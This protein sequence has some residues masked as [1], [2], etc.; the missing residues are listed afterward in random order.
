VQ[1]IP[2]HT[3]APV[4]VLRITTPPRRDAGETQIKTFLRHDGCPTLSAALTTPFLSLQS[5]RYSTRY[6]P[7]KHFFLNLSNARENLK[8]LNDVSISSLLL[9]VS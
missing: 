9:S 8:N 1:P 3:N 7:D 4:Q 5:I 6:N 2:V